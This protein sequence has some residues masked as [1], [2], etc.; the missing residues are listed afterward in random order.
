MAISTLAAS[1]RDKDIA[2]SVPVWKE[3]ANYVAYSPEL[4]I[5]SCGK[6]ASQAKKQLR[7][8]PSLFIEEAARVGTLEEI[9]AESGFERRGKTSRQRPILAREKMRLTLPA[10]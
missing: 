6:S 7:E 3:G 8:A 10:V 2:F 5:S 9:V 1:N 4:N